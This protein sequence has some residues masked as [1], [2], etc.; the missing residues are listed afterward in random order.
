MS[1]SLHPNLLLK[2]KKKKTTSHIRNTKS[3]IH[4]FF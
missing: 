4:F 3:E 1:V 2:K